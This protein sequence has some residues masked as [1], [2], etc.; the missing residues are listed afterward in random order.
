MVGHTVAVVIFALPWLAGCGPDTDALRARAAFDLRCSF[1]Q[2]TLTQLGGEWNSDVYGVQGCGHRATYVQV[3]HGTW[4]MNND[5]Q[6]NS[7][8][9]HPSQ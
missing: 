2:L 5:D 7:A 9:H 4:I 1:D 3:R 8:I 6:Q